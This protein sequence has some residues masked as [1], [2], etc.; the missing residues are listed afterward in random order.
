MR[1]EFAPDLRCLA[2]FTV[3]WIIVAC[4]LRLMLEARWQYEP[5]RRE[6]LGD[7]L[8]RVLSGCFDGDNAYSVMISVMIGV[9]LV[10][11][12]VHTLLVVLCMSLTP[13]R[14]QWRDIARWAAYTTVQY[15]VLISV[16]MIVVGLFPNESSRRWMRP[17]PIVILVVATTP[18]YIVA[19]HVWLWHS[20][21]AELA[22]HAPPVITDIVVLFI[23]IVGFWL[24]LGILL[25]REIL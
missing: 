15:L 10:I 21:R 18:Y 13:P 4:M 14:W 9:T 16:V 23:G 24:P 19:R 8:S 7:Y 2:G 22:Q 11:C 25:Q 1:P 12:L 17:D 20:A 5:S 3:G 6:S